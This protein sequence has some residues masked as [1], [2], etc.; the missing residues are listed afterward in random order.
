MSDGARSE[1]QKNRAERNANVSVDQKM[2]CMYKSF[3]LNSL[4][5]DSTKVPLCLIV[6]SMYAVCFRKKNV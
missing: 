1:C 4:F 3:L 5:Y 6:F 2:S